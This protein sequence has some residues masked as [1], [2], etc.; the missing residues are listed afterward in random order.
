MLG[1]SYNGVFDMKEAAIL[2]LSPSSEVGLLITIGRMTNWH[3]TLH[4]QSIFIAK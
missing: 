2:S 1:T 4:V 3:L